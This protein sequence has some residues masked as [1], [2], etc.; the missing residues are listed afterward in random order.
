MSFRVPS[1]IRFQTK[2]HKFPI[3]NNVHH[4][5]GKANQTT[6]E[7]TKVNSLTVTNTSSYDVKIQFYFPDHNGNPIMTHVLT[8]GE[9][10][11]LIS[12]EAPFFIMD[13]DDMRI[14]ANYEDDDATDTSSDKIHCIA[15]GTRIIS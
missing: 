14:R 15:M 5:F 11:H 1:D 12:S 2:F 4:V 13:D 9:T 3:D 8:G 10:Q 6:T 7:L